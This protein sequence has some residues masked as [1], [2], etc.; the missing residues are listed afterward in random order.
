MPQY[1][2]FLIRK[3]S[4]NIRTNGRLNTLDRGFP[5]VRRRRALS[6]ARGKDIA[7]DD[8][9]GREHD[10]HAEDSQR[11]TSGRPAAEKHHHEGVEWEPGSNAAEHA[12]RHRAI[13]AGN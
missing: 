10:Q 12:E 11:E 7:R 9:A 2:R 5:H 8:A 1:I 13:I 3:M 6:H 4:G